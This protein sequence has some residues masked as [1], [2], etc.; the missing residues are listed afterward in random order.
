MR[1]P[2]FDSGVYVLWIRL[3]ITPFGVVLWGRFLFCFF[4]ESVGVGVDGSYLH[5]C[6]GGEFGDEGFGYGDVS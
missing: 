3:Y 2:I 5:A 1:P 4:P 6:E